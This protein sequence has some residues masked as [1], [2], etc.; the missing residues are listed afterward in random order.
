MED[1]LPAPQIC[2]SHRIV[3]FVNNLRN[4]VASLLELF[5]SNTQQARIITI[6]RILILYFCNNDLNNIL[7]IKNGLIMILMSIQ[8]DF[9]L[10]L[11]QDKKPLYQLNIIKY[12]SSFHVT[13]SI[14]IIQIS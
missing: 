8:K 4:F 9:I 5:T 6:K 1:R 10:Q 11:I 2:C 7:H 3:Y 13:Y 14:N 12:S